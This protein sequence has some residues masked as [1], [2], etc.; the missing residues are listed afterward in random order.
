VPFC[1]V[2]V[3]SDDATS[4]YLMFKLPK[5]QSDIRNG[6][7]K[8]WEHCKVN[9]LSSKQPRSQTEMKLRN[10]HKQSCFWAENDHWSCFLNG[11]H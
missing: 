11:Q 6:F 1:K 7:A 2:K 5:I 10:S 9:V 3:K 4:D 8:K